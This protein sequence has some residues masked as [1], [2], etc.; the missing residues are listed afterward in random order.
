M[1]ACD[2]LTEGYWERKGELFLDKRAQNYS[3]YLTFHLLSLGLKS[4][5][6]YETP[7]N[8]RLS[9]GMRKYDIGFTVSGIRS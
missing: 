3:V 6:H 8:K 7:A 1:H 4:D 5:L 9:H 2:S